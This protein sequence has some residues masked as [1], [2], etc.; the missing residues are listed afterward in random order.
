MSNG[1]GNFPCQREA[2]KYLIDSIWDLGTQL[3]QFKDFKSSIGWMPSFGFGA[4]DMFKIFK[5]SE[6]TGMTT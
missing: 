1:V 3:N 6:G 2:M 4:M 5:P